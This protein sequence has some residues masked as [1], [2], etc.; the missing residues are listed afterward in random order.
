MFAAGTPQAELFLAARTGDTAKAA[1]LLEACSVEA[2]AHDEWQATPLFYASLCG[3]A[4]VVRILLRAGAKCEV[5]MVCTSLAQA[6]ARRADLSAMPQRLTYDGE[7]CLYA[8]LNDTTRQAL[9][10]EGFAFA[11]ARSHGVRTWLARCALPG[12]DTP[13]CDAQTRS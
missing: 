8:A 3:H 13:T 6:Q 1:Y 12:A 9:L 7:R 2:D 4:D 10:D 5:R 11:A